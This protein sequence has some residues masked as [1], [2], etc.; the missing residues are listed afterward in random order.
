PRW[1][2]GVVDGVA[3]ADS[4]QV[5]AVTLGLPVYYFP[6]RDVRADLF[7][8]S[9]RKESH[10]A[11]GERSFF[12]LRVGDRFIENA[13]WRFEAPPD[14]APKLGEYVALYWDR[15]DHWYEEDDEV[16]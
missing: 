12:H 4:K 2:R 13:A 6:L 9:D 15:L 16:F 1:V 5:L 3:I 14:E 8:S 10:P 7:E 11:L